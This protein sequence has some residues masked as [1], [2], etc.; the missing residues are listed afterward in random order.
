MIYDEKSA[1]IKE[2]RHHTVEPSKINL[3]CLRCDYV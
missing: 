3:T 2:Y 1:S